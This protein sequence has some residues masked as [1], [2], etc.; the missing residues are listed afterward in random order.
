MHILQIWENYFQF[1]EIFANCDAMHKQK[2][3]VTFNNIV[4]YIYGL[5]K[6]DHVSEYTSL[7]YGMSFD[8]LIKIRVLT[9]LHKVI[10]T[11]QPMYLY[12]HL[13][14]S[15]SLR[16]NN[17]VPIK[18]TSLKSKRQFLIYS[19]HLWNKIPPQFQRISD[20]RK[21]KN[22]ILP[23][24][25]E[26]NCCLQLYLPLNKYTKDYSFSIRLEWPD[27]LFIV[28]WILNKRSSAYPALY[29]YIY[30]LK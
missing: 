13:R 7:V 5:R 26:I 12:E 14:F 2:L 24:I 25:N 1:C 3:N 16:N 11:Q 30:I 19:I 17:V 23:I 4:R 29:K 10:N 8:N 22:S 20:V 15:R 18:H 6:Y 28:D 27:E 21:F 9:L